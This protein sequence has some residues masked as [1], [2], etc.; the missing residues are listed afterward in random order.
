MRK[1]VVDET[2]SF[3]KR[4]QVVTDYLKSLYARERVTEL[5]EHKNEPKQ[6][7]NL[8]KDKNKSR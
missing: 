2:I 1:M 4:L 8:K 3:E 7:N 6:I 5:R